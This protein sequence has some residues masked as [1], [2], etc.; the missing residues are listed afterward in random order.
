[1]SQTGEWV[2]KF[3]MKEKLA[4]L[5]TF[6]ERNNGKISELVYRKP[7]HS[8]QYLQYSSHHKTSCKESVASSLFNK[9]YFIITNKDDLTKENSRIKQVL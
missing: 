8:D 7:T 1:M 5:D 9:A 4:F 6:L 2:C 3:T